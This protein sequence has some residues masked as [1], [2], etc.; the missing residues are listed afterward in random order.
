MRWSLRYKIFALMGS[1][2]LG[3]L[4]ATLLV[5][6]WQAHRSAWQRIVDDLHHTRRQF[7]ALQQLRY[8]NL[9]ALSRILG[10][11]YALR[12]ALATYD[13]PTVFSAMQTFQARIQ[14]DVFLI[15]DDRGSVLAATTCWPGWPGTA[16]SRR[17]SAGVRHA[18]R[19]SC[20]PRGRR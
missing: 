9:L 13:P 6:G 19:S 3:F 12:N 8:Q 18:Q 15:T 4:M 7:A 5:V 16:Y 10:R 17:G 1:M 2:V 20:W 14:S 11:E